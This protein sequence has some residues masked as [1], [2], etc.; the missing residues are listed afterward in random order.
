MTNMPNPS[1]ENPEG[2][3]EIQREIVSAVI[4]SKDGKILLG[5]KVKNGVYS[6]TWHLPGGGIEQG[7]ELVT[8]LKRE[9]NEE[10]GLEIEEVEMMD[11]ADGGTSVKTINNER[12]F[13]RMKFNVYQVHLEQNASEI[14]ISPSDEFSEMKWVDAND[15][16]S[17]ELTPPGRR[18]FVKY[19]YIQEAS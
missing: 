9:V 8:A 12:V 2:L 13:V 18:L 17:I 3:P 1:Q 11:D 4:F 14:Q 19:G 7:E 6:E 10:T 5:K 15:L 16:G